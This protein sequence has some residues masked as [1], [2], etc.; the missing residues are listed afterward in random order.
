MTPTDLVERLAVFLQ[1]EVASTFSLETKHGSRKNP[2]V[3]EGAWTL[4]EGDDQDEDAVFPYIA[5]FAEELN[6]TEA[7]AKLKVTIFFGTYCEGGK[8]KK[9]DVFKYDT[10]GYKDL[11]NIIER[12][13]QALLKARFIDQKYKIEMPLKWQIPFEQPY[14][15]WVGWME[16]YWIIQKPLYEGDIFD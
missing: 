13:R 11:L 3:I 7:E 14:P 5:V 1:N 16:T 8:N 12:V 6:E 15:Q 4:P 9:D 2:R 10:Q